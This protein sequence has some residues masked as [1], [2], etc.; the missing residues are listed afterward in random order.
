M[1][2]SSLVRYNGGGKDAFV[3]GKK[4]KTSRICYGLVVEGNKL[5]M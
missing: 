2:S 1:V 3:S 5:D 4:E